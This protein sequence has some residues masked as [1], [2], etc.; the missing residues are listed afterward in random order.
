MHSV[1]RTIGALK[2]D[3][4]YEDVIDNSF[5]ERLMKSRG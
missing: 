1:V 5:V 3:V 4:P 2:V